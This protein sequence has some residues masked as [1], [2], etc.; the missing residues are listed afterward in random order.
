MCPVLTWPFEQSILRLASLHQAT[1]QHFCLYLRLHLNQ[2][3]LQCLPLG[4]DFRRSSFAKESM[5]KFR[6]KRAPGTILQKLSSNQKHLQQTHIFEWWNQTCAYFLSFWGKEKENGILSFPPV[7][8]FHASWNCNRVK[9]CITACHVCVVFLWYC[10]VQC[11]DCCL[12]KTMMRIW[13]TMGVVGTWVALL[14]FQSLTH[15][16][17]CHKFLSQ[18]LFLQHQIWTFQA[19]NIIVYPWKN[20]FLKM[21]RTQTRKQALSRFISKMGRA[22]KNQCLCLRL[23]GQTRYSLMSTNILWWN[24]AITWKGFHQVALATTI[25]FNLTRSHQMQSQIEAAVVLSWQNMV[26]LFIFV[27]FETNKL[28]RKTV[29]PVLGKMRNDFCAVSWYV[30]PICCSGPGWITHVH[31]LWMIILQLL[32]FT[33]IDIQTL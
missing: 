28:S 8:M 33:M 17:E 22:T 30:H 32:Q 2:S 16:T 11:Q 25:P 14:I 24:V 10:S 15:A 18:H 26:S 13:W 3:N 27:P 9:D 4:H 7:F 23:L 12:W 20:S 29:C 6:S 31:A 5:W 21:S 19:I 1:E